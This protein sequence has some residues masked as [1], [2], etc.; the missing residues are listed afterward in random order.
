MSYIIQQTSAINT[1]GGASATASFSRPVT[2]GSIIVVAAAAIDHGAPSG[3]GTEGQAAG[4][5]AAVSDSQDNSYGALTGDNGPWVWDDFTAKALWLGQYVAEGVAAGTT[6]I[7]FEFTPYSSAPNCHVGIVV[8]E[9]SGFNSTYYLAQDNSEIAVN[10]AEPIGIDDGS[11]FSLSLADGPVNLYIECA[12]AVL[13][14]DYRAVTGGSGYTFDGSAIA[15]IGSAY[16]TL[17]FQHKVNSTITFED[18]VHDTGA[19]GDV[20][21]DFAAAVAFVN[22]YVSNSAF[23]D[24]AVITSGLPNAVIGQPYNQTLV[25][26]ASVAPYTW[27]II[28]GSLP[29]GLSLNSSTGVISGTPL[30]GGNFAPQFEVSDSSSP[31]GTA[32]ATLQLD[33]VAGGGGGFHAHFDQYNRPLTSI[34]GQQRPQPAPYRRPI[35]NPK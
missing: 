23:T 18:N 20:P 29:A 13:L 24:L 34:G 7:T 12:A 26:S 15:Q 1:A 17:G 22:Q 32:T 14:D 4:S 2:A 11:Y 30:V 27:S 6:E 35:Y 5:Q 16:S 21:T 3:A 10:S 19:F 31:V 8:Y 25:A 28:S 9:L 33:C